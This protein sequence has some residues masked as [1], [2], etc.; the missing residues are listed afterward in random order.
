MPAFFVH[1]SGAI[2]PYTCCIFCSCYTSPYG[3]SENSG[4]PKSF[5]PTRNRVF[6]YKPSI[7]G[8]PN[9]WKHPYMYTYIRHCPC[10]TTN[11]EVLF[12][13]VPNHFPHSTHRKWRSFVV[14]QW[15]EVWQ[16][17]TSLKKRKMA[18]A[19]R[20]GTTCH[21]QLAVY[22]TKYALKQDVL[23]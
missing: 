23:G 7:L 19:S 2:V 12:S 22:N 3:C 13:V 21:F 9:F 18:R 16:R 10:L 4:T 1:I 5:H 8:S 20:Y 11:L 15:I 17:I 14:C 6:H